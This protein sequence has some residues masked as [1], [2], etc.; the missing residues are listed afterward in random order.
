[1]AGDRH[2]ILHKDKKIVSGHLFGLEP[3]IGSLDHKY[4]SFNHITVKQH[5]HIQLNIFNN[6]RRRTRMKPISEAKINNIKALFGKGL[7]LR[8]IATQTGVSKSKIGEIKMILDVDT[9]DVKMGPPR[10]M[11]VADDRAAARLIRSG[12]ADTC[13]EA[14]QYLNSSKEEPVHPQTVR[15]HMRKLGMKAVVKKRKPLL[16]KLHRK[17]RLNFANLYKEWTIED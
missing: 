14:A 2:V 11:T 9:S 12:K 17:A 5:H 10:K 7:S 13:V 6:R 4:I 8:Q 1:M 3:I 16:S 15:N